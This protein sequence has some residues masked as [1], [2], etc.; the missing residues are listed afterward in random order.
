[1]NKNNIKR[2][3]QSKVFSIIGPIFESFAKES[4]YKM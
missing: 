4:K 1:M 2:G 3:R